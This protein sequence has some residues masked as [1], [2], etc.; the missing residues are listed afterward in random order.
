[1]NAAT[2][3][4]TE[5]PEDKLSTPKEAPAKD[6]KEA[7]DEAE[8][9][10]SSQKADQII[11]VAT[12]LLDL[13]DKENEALRAHDDDVVTG[14]VDMKDN[15]TRLYADHLDT[16]AQN[17]LLLEDITE[18]QQGALRELNDELNVA[19]ALNAR[20]LQAEMEAGKRLITAIVDAAKDQA[21][22]NATYSRNGA[23]DQGPKKGERS[24]LTFSKD[25]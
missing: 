23:L 4:D 15:L 19:V 22:V 12:L 9:V 24:S 14:M 5:T 13:L 21:S 10:K 18:E 3:I 20:L 8:E 2:P 17:P 11:E 6:I 7:M 16:V 25:T 1:M